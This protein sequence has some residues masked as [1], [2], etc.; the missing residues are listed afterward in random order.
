MKKLYSSLFILLTLALHAAS[1]ISCQEF[2]I[3]SQPEG[4][5]KI[6]I[7]AQDTYTVLATAPN[8]IVFNISSNTPWT[9]S[10]SAQW[11]KITPSMSAASSLVSE[12]VVAIESNSGLNT[13]SANIKIKAEG[14]EVEKII[15]I[16]QASKENLVVIPYDQLA[17]TE[18][19][20]IS[21]TLASNKAWKIIPS[22]AFLSNIDKK[23]G[24]G[25]VDAKEEKITITLPSNP[26]AKREGKITVKTEFEEYTFDITQNGVI[27]E[28]EEAPESTTVKVGGTSTEK[29]IKIRSN[30]EWKVEVP[31]AYQPWLKAEA[32]SETE[33]KLTTTVNNLL[34]NRIGQ[35]RLKTKEIIDGFEGVVFEIEQSSAYNMNG[36]TD[37]YIIDQATGYVKVLG[38]GNIN[39]TYLFKKGRLTFDF[40]SINI[41]SGDWIEF[42]MWTDFG[43]QP[44]F[45]LHFK[46]DAISNFTCGGGLNWTQK[47][48]TWTAA[49]V[50]AVRKLEFLVDYK[51]GN[52]DLLVLKLIA[53]NKEV[54]ILDNNIKDC[55]KS[56]DDANYPGQT[57]WL[58]PH[59]RTAEA[60]YIVKSITWEPIE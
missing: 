20:D 11:C 58:K 9:I 49:Q 30:K 18:G 57:V 14:I 44:N 13:R 19:G 50:N 5:A 40:E 29:I 38:G 39:S 60:N 23:T 37:K 31:T 34:I 55:Y 41:S 52:T 15:T 21:F 42:N 3:D 6:Q 7:D 54:A 22:T 25:T 2:H 47:T 56:G 43:R 51:E 28:Q 53:D 24:E 32:L 4:P 10:S 17:P 27:I 35:I 59:Y 12:I 46:A 36:G 16:V 45:H 26:G 1:F 48:F 33:L 8:N